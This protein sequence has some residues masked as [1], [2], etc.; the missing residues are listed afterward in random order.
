MFTVTVSIGRN[1]GT[2]IWAGAPLDGS[3]WVEFRRE[4]SEVVRFLSHEDMDGGGCFVDSAL[5]DNSPDELGFIEESATW[6]AAVASES[7]PALKQALSEIGALYFQR[8]IALTIG[9]TVFVE[10]RRP[11]FEEVSA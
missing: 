3:R 6:V 1:L 2:G 7:I 10:S 9:E 5:C 4:V 8:C 11:A